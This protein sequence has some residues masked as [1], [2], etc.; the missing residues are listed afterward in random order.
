MILVSFTFIGHNVK[1]EANGKLWDASIIHEN[2]FL[3]NLVASSDATILEKSSDRYTELFKWCQDH[4]D[5][6]DD[7]VSRQSN[8]VFK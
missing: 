3:E 1:V 7:I 6:C 4:S 5:F 2:E 8:F